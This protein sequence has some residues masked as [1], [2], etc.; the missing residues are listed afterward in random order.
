MIGARSGGIPEAVIDDVNGYVLPRTVE[1]F[2]EAIERLA[3]D[4]PELE[5]LRAGALSVFRDKFDIMKIVRRYHSVY[6]DMQDV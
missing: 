5:R 3:F 2:T 1:A 6:C 4:R